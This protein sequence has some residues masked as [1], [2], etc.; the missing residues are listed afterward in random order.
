MLLHIL[1]VGQ[2]GTNC[3]ILGCEETKEALVIDPGAEASRILQWLDDKGLKAKYIVNTHGHI[4]HIGAN[5]EIREA[6]GAKLLIHRED[7]EMLVDPKKNLS[8]FVGPAISL[9]AADETL[10]HGDSIK[11][12]NIKLEV[13][14]TPG[15]SL[16]GI[17]LKFDG[18]LFS[19]DTLFAEGVGRSDFPGGCHETLLASIKRELFTLPDE[20]KVYPGHGPSTTI[21]YE[22]ENNPFF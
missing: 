4:D 15:H 13:M 8:V 19:G 14:H 22:K 11:V 7:A 18:V 16:G 10:E 2:L 9:K 17:S 12:G 1:G 6:T 21:G 3:Y 20:T 5:D